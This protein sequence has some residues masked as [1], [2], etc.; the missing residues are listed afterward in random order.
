[1]IRPKDFEPLPI[2]EVSPLTLSVNARV[3]E[4]RKEAVDDSDKYP[5]TSQ[6]VIQ[7]RLRLAE[8]LDTVGDWS[9]QKLVYDG[10]KTVSAAQLHEKLEP[11]KAEQ[12]GFGAT[13]RLRD[14]ILDLQYIDIVERKGLHGIN[15]R[16]GEL[17]SE[18]KTR[19]KTDKGIQE[20]EE[21]LN[22]L[23]NRAIY[24]FPHLAKGVEIVIDPKAEK[25]TRAFEDTFGHDYNRYYFTQLQK[26]HIAQGRELST[27]WGIPLPYGFTTGTHGSGER[28]ATGASRQDVYFTSAHPYQGAAYGIPTLAIT[29]EAPLIVPR[30]THFTL[31]EISHVGLVE[32]PK[33]V[34]Y[35]KKAKNSQD[36]EL[37]D[38]M[39]P[40]LYY[41]CFRDFADYRA[42]RKKDEMRL[43]KLSDEQFNR[44]WGK[45]L[46]PQ[47]SS[48]LWEDD[49]QAEVTKKCFL[50]MVEET[51]E[52]IS[53][54]EFTNVWE[55]KP[56]E[57][58]CHHRSA[59]MLNSYLERPDKWT[60]K[61]QE[62]KGQAIIN[63]LAAIPVQ[64]RE[65]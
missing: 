28:A 40:T 62:Y 35:I 42:F 53:L 47:T 22:D 56:T 19:D 45:L 16:I 60:G 12:V 59:Y 48:N 46:E 20:I 34:P 37:L 38:R 58:N 8:V 27:T 32:K 64:P 49:Y 18:L 24:L 29:L 1:M 2:S 63:R 36:Y 26:V 10:G 50:A 17:F 21:K 51:E 41:L 11:F 43:M 33:F 7:T 25:N 23:L 65:F 9:G 57:A 13:D 6:S 52:A 30:E 61:V 54:F 14:L 5:S 44:L 3:S 15:E 55:F 39:D 31:D 4:I